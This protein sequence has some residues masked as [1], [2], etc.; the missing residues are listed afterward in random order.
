MES[1]KLK[2]LVATA[3]PEMRKLSSDVQKVFEAH[4]F[5]D[6]IDCRTI[7]TIALGPDGK[8]VISC[9]LICDW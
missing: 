7:C 6:P 1:L 9:Q 5:A 3:Q 4:G 2:A 8:P